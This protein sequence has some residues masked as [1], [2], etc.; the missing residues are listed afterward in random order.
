MTSVGKADNI[1][2]TDAAKQTLGRL[3]D[4][5]GDIILHVT[6]GFTKAPIC[7]SAGEIRLGSL[8]VFLGKA[9]GVPVYEMQITPEA[10][11]SNGDDE[12]VLDVVAGVPIGFSLDPGDGMNFTIAR[13]AK[14]PERPA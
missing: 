12:Y 4:R 14:R 13:Q 9:D 5:Y 11:N 8:D 10:F 2:V 1:V 6:G 7:L 3:R